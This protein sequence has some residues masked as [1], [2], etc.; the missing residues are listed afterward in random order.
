ME[1][2]LNRRDF[3]KKAAL[4]CSLAA[5]AGI[6]GVLSYSD[7][8]VRH[9]AEKIYTFK[10]FRVSNNNLK[11]VLAIVHGKSP[12]KMVAAALD[13]L[14]G[15]SR[16]IN[17]GE[18]VLIKPNVAWDRQPEQAVNTN[19]EIV[20]A[21][22]KLCIVAGAKEVWVTDVSINDPQRC[23][24]R[25]GIGDAVERAGGIIKIPSG[26]DMLDTD[27]KGDVL[28]IWPVNK[29]FHQVD[30]V[31]NLPIAKQHSLSHCSFSM[32]NWYGVLGGRRNRLHQEIDQS[33]ADLAF[34][35]RP[36]FTILDATRVLKHNGPTGGDL[37][38][39]SVENTIIAGLD[40]VAIDSYGLKF[41]DLKIEDVKFLNIAVK[42]GVGITNYKSL[43]FVEIEV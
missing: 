23:F 17:K 15:I 11:P 36:T 37:S 24:K 7:Q 22:V 28:K 26:S 13:Q 14:G 5:G 34:A 33:I 3:L 2:K 18:H 19:P 16:F 27:L 29:F 43:N 41:L 35:I 31:I 9:T 1:N 21:V 40:E 4:T 12:E 42:K 32:K 6:I 8:P 25:S 20:S 30:K 38:D 10:D 39:V